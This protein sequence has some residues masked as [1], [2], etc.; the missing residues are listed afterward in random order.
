M[1]IYEAM[2]LID[3]KGGYENLTLPEKMNTDLAFDVTYTQIAVYHRRVQSSRW[4]RIGRRYLDGLTAHKTETWK[5]ICIL[6]IGCVSAWYNFG[7]VLTLR[8]LV[9]GWIMFVIAAA[10]YIYG[11]GWLERRK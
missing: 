4:K 11:K 10:A 6:S 5:L 9:S 2:D 1:N 3:E 8:S 7:T